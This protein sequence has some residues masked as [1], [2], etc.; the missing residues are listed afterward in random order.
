MLRRTVRSAVGDS[1]EAFRQIRLPPRS[2][3]QSYKNGSAL[4]K[5][6]DFLFQKVTFSFQKLR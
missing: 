6:S 4:A 5:S 3:A 2:D 1:G